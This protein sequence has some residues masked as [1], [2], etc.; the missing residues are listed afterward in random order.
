MLQLYGSHNLCGSRELSCVCYIFFLIVRPVIDVV[1]RT[2]P[3]TICRV[4]APAVLKA[5]LDVMIPPEST[6]SGPARLLK[7]SI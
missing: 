4:M 1:K 6:Q 3:C 7:L 2:D 5:M